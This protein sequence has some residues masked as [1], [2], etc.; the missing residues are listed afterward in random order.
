[1]TTH[2]TILSSPPLAPVMPAIRSDIPIPKKLLTR[3]A[4]K[5]NHVRVSDKDT[6][7]A[8]LKVGDSFLLDYPGAMQSYQKHAAKHGWVLDYL[9]VYEPLY[10]SVRVW[11]IS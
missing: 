9:R 10:N 2:L 1:M 5:T 8:S 7:V 6:F 4:R 11:R 3:K